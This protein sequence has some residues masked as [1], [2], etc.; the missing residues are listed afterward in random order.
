MGR[1]SR[2][3]SATSIALLQPFLR[4]TSS[5]SHTGVWR[6][7]LNLTSHYWWLNKNC[8]LQFCATCSYLGSVPYTV[9]HEQKWH[10][11]HGT[12]TVPLSRNWEWV[13]LQGKSC[14]AS[15]L[16]EPKEQ[17]QTWLTFFL[18]RDGTVI[19]LKKGREWGRE[20]QKHHQHNLV[21][22]SASHKSPLDHPQ[23]ITAK[24]TMSHRNLI[25]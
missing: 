20:K 14:L 24:K 5:E 13:Y 18:L 19:N 12:G 22:I 8:S 2:E 17:Q 6:C 9:V 25:L 1:R 16:W 23:A 11:C 7:K 15:R 21:F 4:D 10:C 3:L